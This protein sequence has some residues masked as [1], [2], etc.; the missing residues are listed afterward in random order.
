MFCK[1]RHTEFRVW[2]G[3]MYVYV[4]SRARATLEDRRRG[5]NEDEIVRRISRRKPSKTRCYINNWKRTPSEGVPRATRKLNNVVTFTDFAGNRERSRTSPA[6][7]TTTSTGGTRSKF[8][9]DARDLRLVSRRLLLCLAVSFE[10]FNLQLDDK[11]IHSAINK[12]VSYG[13]RM[14][15]LLDKWIMSLSLSTYSENRT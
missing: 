5:G 13:V 4:C 2:N 15:P 14:S 3:Y 7:I 10:M 1:R 8:M 11:S 9:F 12:V 6:A